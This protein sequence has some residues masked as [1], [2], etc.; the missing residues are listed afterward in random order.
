MLIKN[1]LRA[2]A[3]RNDPFDEQSYVFAFT[4]RAYDLTRQRGDD[5]WF[6]PDKY[7]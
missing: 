1:C 4:N 2:R 3:R 7:D 5:G 6:E